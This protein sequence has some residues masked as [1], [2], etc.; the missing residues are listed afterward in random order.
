MNMTRRVY[1][2]IFMATL[3]SYGCVP[4][5]TQ[6]EHAMHGAPADNL[7]DT[8]QLSP[9]VKALLTREMI[10]LQKGM[11]EIVPALVA[12]KWQGISEI[13]NRMHDS[14]IMKNSLTDA[15]MHELHTSLPAPFQ[16]LDHSFH[17]SARLMAEAAEKQDS[18]KVAYYY[19]RLT[20]T[21]IECHAKYATEKFPEFSR[22]A[23]HRKE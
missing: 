17:H 23:Q 1:S 18:E 16:Q 4:V 14:Y 10:E 2:I 12:A 8:V 6:D 22:A 9:E 7:P 11:K 19:F 3:I 15:Q 5:N 21:C 13:G 20:E